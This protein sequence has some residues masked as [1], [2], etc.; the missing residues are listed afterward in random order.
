MGYFD[1]KAR[2]AF[3]AAGGDPALTG[4]LAQWAEAARDRDDVA[5][6]IVAEDGTIIAE[7]IRRG[8]LDGARATYVSD[9]DRKLGLF[10]DEVGIALGQIHH[11][12][13]QRVIHLTR[14]QLTR[15]AGAAVKD[16]GLDGLDD[17]TAIRARRD[18]A[19]AALKQAALDAY[20]AGR[21]KSAIAAAAGITRKTLDDWIARR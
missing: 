2:E 7:T 11:K 6:V 3:A 13:G 14:A 8:H 10:G 1:A 18:E 4:P 12:I 15:G 16:P 17:L 19:A 5:G 21:Q 20:D 9:P